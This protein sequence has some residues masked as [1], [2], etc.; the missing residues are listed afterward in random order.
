MGLGEADDVLLADE[1][2]A[3]S[4]HVEVAAELGALGHETVHVLIGE[5]EHVAV[6]GGPATHAVLVAG[7]RGVKEDD[8]GHV[9]LVLLGVGGRVAQAAEGGLVAA[10]QDGRLEHVVVG[11]VDDVPE[12]LLPL[13]ARVQA[14]ADA[15]D[16]AGRGVLEQ[17]ARHVEQLL[18]VLLAVGAAGRLDD[19]I[20]SEAECGALGLVGDLGLHVRSSPI[21]ASLYRQ[22]RNF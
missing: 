1:G 5:V 17:V 15:A 8:P 18:E 2:L 4:Q 22:V 7:A 6:V 3:A 10:V 9:A 13:G 11:V 21:A 19:L 12:E 20:E 14:V 16:G